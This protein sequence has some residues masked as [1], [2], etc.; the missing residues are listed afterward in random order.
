MLLR[1]SSNA[2]IQAGEL[3]HFLAAEHVERI[4]IP[5]RL[6]RD[7][8]DVHASGN[9][10]VF[11]NPYKLLTIA[12]KLSERLIQLEPEHRVYFEGQLKAFEDDWQNKILEWEDQAAHLK[13]SQFIIHH[14]SCC[15]LYT[16]PSP[17]D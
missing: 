4:D 13:G 7:Q 9:P 10:H 17:R 8:G 1:Q 15:L 14:K 5:S 11:W 2:A 6:D 12:R 16:S 3:G